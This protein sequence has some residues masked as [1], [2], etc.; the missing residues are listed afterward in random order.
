VDTAAATDD[1]V[2]RIISS[3]DKKAPGF[4]GSWRFV[5]EKIE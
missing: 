5:G 2:A 3:S 1:K 4:A